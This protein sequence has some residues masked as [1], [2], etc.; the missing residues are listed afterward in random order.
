MRRD[1][2][3]AWDKY[4]RGAADAMRPIAREARRR[5]LTVRS[6]ADRAE[7][8]VKVV[9]RWF[10]H[11]PRLLTVERACEALR[12]SNPKLVARA[13]LGHNELF[14]YA[15]QAVLRALK[16]R[17]ALFDD[18]RKLRDTLRAAIQRASVRQR[19]AA[20]T[21]FA[22]VQAGLQD[23]QE[24][25]PFLAPELFALGAALNLDLGEHVIDSARFAYRESEML[26][27]RD[28]TLEAFP[29]SLAHRAAISRIFSRYVPQSSRPPSVALAA[30]QREYRRHLPEPG[31]LAH[32]LLGFEP[33][34][35]G[36]HER[37]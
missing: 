22:L 30:A 32:A 34:R 20:F 27:A 28:W 25:D 6:F 5:G 36:N 13:L 14:K 9:I 11:T 23:P 16:Q 8:D 12:L 31:T 15:E 2:E 37:L 10:E 21:A 4:E 29:L 7:R 18:E 26:A 24:G 19:K 1:T 33:T 3:A 35:K 17:R